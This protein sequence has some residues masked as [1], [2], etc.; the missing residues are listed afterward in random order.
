MHE[1][2]EIPIHGCVIDSDGR[3]CWKLF[4]RLAHVALHSWCRR[5]P[6][7]VIMSF[8]RISHLLLIYMHNS[9]EILISSWARSQVPNNFHTLYLSYNL[10]SLSANP[11]INSP[12]MFARPKSSYMLCCWALHHPIMLPE[13][14][15]PFQFFRV[16]MSLLLEGWW[17]NQWLCLRVP[18]VLIDSLLITAT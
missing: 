18:M 17:L 5:V 4:L 11:Q 3:V 10:C 7:S 14:L 1:S 12:A 9:K 2:E 15:L 16:G 13:R 6:S 8:P